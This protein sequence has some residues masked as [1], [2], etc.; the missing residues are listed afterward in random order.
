MATQSAGSQRLTVTKLTSKEARPWEVE[1]NKGVTPAHCV[2]SARARLV[3]LV[4]GVPDTFD[5]PIAIICEDLA[6]AATLAVGQAID[7]VL[8]AD[9]KGEGGL[10]IKWRLVS[11]TPVA[12]K[13]AA[14]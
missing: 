2:I 8:Y 1:G 12:P 6:L 4:D 3:E 13:K 10:K 14:T 5:K 7:A 9:G 11:L